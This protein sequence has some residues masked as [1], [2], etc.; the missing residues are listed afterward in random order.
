MMKPLF[1]FKQGQLP[2]LVSMP[3]AGTSIASEVGAQMLPLAQ[4]V[5]DTDWH[6]PLLYDMLEELGVSLIHANYSRYVIDLNRPSDDNNLYPGQDTTGLCPVDTFDKQALYIDGKTPDTVELQ[7]RVQIYWQPYHQQLQAELERLRAKHGIAILWDAHSIASQV[8]RFFEG[9][10][11]D[12]NFGTAGGKSCDLSL[13]ETIA[14]SMQAYR[15]EPAYSHVFNGRFKGG[16]ITRQYGQP[17]RNIHAVQLEMSQCIYM[18]EAAPY[19]YRPDLAAQ[20]QPLLK[21][22]LSSCINWAQ[23]QPGAKFMSQSLFARN[24]LL[25]DGWAKDVRLY[26][27]DDG[28]LISV[29]VGASPAAHEA[30]RRICRARHDQPAFARLPAR[31]GRHDRNR[32]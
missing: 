1:Q 25:K 12:L 16:Y 27:N 17:E 19:A 5:A 21:S 31:H 6:L 30:A 14:R 15:A 10:L 7:R 18:N 28:D 13:Q 29:E 4:Q 26:W 3:H 32:R 23:Q 9:K 2:L 20:V 8:P 22:L 24:A 11:P